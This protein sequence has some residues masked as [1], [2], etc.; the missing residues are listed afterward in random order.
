MNNTLRVLSV[1]TLLVLPAFA[2]DIHEA[3]KTGD[4]QKVQELIKNDPDLVNLKDISGR[5]PLHWAARNDHLNIVKFLV[6]NGADVNAE[7]NQGISPLFYSVWLGGNYEIAECL[8]NI[9]ADVNFKRSNGQTLL[10]L[11][12]REGIDKTAKLL[13]EKGADL[14]QPDAVGK[15]PLFISVENRHQNIVELLL[16]HGAQTSLKDNFGRTPLH[17]SAI[18]GYIQISALLVANGADVN[19]QDHAGKTP[20]HYAG[21]YG[22]EKL[23]RLLKS[24]GGETKE[25]IENFGFSPLLQKNLG[26][27]E[28]LIWYLGHS[29]WAVKTKSTFLVFD[30]W[31]RGK[32]DQPL[33]VNGRINPEEI[34]D[35]DVYVFSSH[36]HYDHY[37]EIIFDWENT[38]DRLTYIFGWQ[39]KRGKKHVCLSARGKKTTGNLEVVMVNSPE[40]DP[41]DNAFLVKTDD[42]SVY[43]AGDYGLLGGI[44]EITPIYNQDMQFLKENA[45]ELDIM[46]L[47]SR[48]IDGK[49]PEYVNFSIETAKPKIFFPMHY[50][51]SEFLLREFADEIAK[52]GYH[53]KVIVPENRGDMYVCRGGKTKNEHKT[54]R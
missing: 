50:Q 7:D 1:L 45:N 46:F 52:S 41:F 51:S 10:Y 49:V 3:V 53:T 34:K 19:E 15:T 21:K 4:L 6:N 48:L 18:E 42:I 36:E 5:T 37:D 30:Y 47:A 16:D 43:H 28:A 22:H 23:A 38:I 33:L 35:L 31:E 20:L 13:I 26:T 40:A 39:N 29:G 54:W 9:G 24:K 8:V 44:E 2:A 12:S 14:N 27:D 32:S 11:A 17:Q 25:K